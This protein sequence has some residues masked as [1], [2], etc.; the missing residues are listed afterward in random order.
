MSTSC[1]VH[2]PILNTRIF[3][4]IKIPFN[5]YTHKYFLNGTLNAL[6][7]KKPSLHEEKKLAHTLYA[8]VLCA[9]QTVTTSLLIA[10]R[11]R[12]FCRLIFFVLSFCFSTLRT[13]MTNIVINISVHYSRFFRTNLGVQ[14]VCL[15]AA[16]AD[17]YRVFR[18]V[19]FS[20]FLFFIQSFLR[21]IF[22]REFYWTR[23]SEHVRIWHE[24]MVQNYAQN[25]IT[26]EVFAFFAVFFV[27]S[28]FPFNIKYARLFR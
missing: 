27:T 11:V 5:I 19:F 28:F 22:L 13:T 7:R 4:Q 18:Y 25:R 6:A 8:P 2:A 14:W 21:I 15:W 17:V 23:A 10:P 9:S 26:I 1:D 24:I 12:L 20:F 16:C 3:N